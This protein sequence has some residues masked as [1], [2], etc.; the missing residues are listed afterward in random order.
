MWSMLVTGLWPFPGERH[1]LW[2]GHAAAQAGGDVHP[3][4]FQLAS[5]PVLLIAGQPSPHQSLWTA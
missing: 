1:A 2:L 5:F 4:K 3:N